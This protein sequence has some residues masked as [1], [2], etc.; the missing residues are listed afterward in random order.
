MGNHQISKIIKVKVEVA[1][2]KKMVNEMY[3][4]PFLSTH[5]V[6]D[7]EPKIKVVNIWSILK[8]EKNLERKKRKHKS[9]KKI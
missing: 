2:I 1:K 5:V 3:D 8:L 9:T 7:I 4:K 6:T